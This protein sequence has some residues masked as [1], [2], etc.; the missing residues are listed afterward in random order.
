MGILP[1]KSTQTTANAAKRRSG[2]L[3]FSGLG[4]LKTT[5]TVGFSTFRDQEVQSA[6][7]K[8]HKRSNGSMSLGTAMEEDSDEDD[9]FET[10]PKID[11]VDDKDIKPTIVEPEDAK[12]G[13][14]TDGIGRIRV[15]VPSRGCLPSAP[16][17]TLRFSRT[18]ETT[19]LGRTGERKCDPVS[20]VSQRGATGRVDARVQPRRRRRCHRRHRR[21][22]H[23]RP[24]R[25]R[26][27]R[28]RQEPAR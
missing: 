17:L 15:C 12:S 22:G 18:A 3:D 8:S 14:L 11:D 16:S 28:P 9:D 6:R 13:E 23:P 4:P 7:R 2:Q 27:R 24:R 5:G 25:T 1:S 19:T 10:L 26:V 20:E 21:P